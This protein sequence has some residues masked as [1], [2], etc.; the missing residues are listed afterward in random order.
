MKDQKATG[1]EKDKEHEAV[2][3]EREQL[4]RDEAERRVKEKEAEIQ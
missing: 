3:A 2:L 1:D 4:I